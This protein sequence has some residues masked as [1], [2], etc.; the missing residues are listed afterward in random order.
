MSPTRRTVVAAPARPLSR[1]AAAAAH[2]GTRRRGPVHHPAGDSTATLPDHG[3]LNTR[4]EHRLHQ[5][6]PAGRAARP[7]G[8]VPA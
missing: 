5:E 8:T 7:E 1:P 3:A 6:A 4:P 2:P